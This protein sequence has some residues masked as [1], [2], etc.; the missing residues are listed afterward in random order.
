MNEFV[1]DTMAIVLHLEKRKSGTNVKQILT[2]AENGNAVVHVPAIVFAEILYLSEKKR[3]V[4]T[5]SDVENHLSKFPNFRSQELSFEIVKTAETITDIPE[6][7]DRLIA[8]TA[9]HLGLKLITND[10]KIQN[11]AFVKT[12]W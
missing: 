6:L 8:A 3:I 1:A 4:L 11:S 7:H 2:D 10:P 5:L 12:V 9:K